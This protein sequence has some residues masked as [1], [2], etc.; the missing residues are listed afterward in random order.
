VYS[1]VED[2]NGDGK[3]DMAFQFSTTALGIP[4]IQPGDMA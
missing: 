2:V 1:H 4:V 3:L